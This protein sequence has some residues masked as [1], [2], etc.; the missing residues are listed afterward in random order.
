M[1]IIKKYWGYA[2]VAL[3][4]LILL[5]G[6][7][8][9]NYQNEISSK[10][11]RF[12]VLANSNRQ[13]DQDLKLEVRDAVIEYLETILET[14]E[15]AEQSEIQ[16]RTHLKDIEAAAQ[17]AVAEQGYSYEVSARLGQNYFPEKS[18]GDMVFPSGMYEA[19]IVDIGNAVGRN[20][21]CVLFPQL[22]FTDA[23]TAYV[24]EE[25]KDTLRDLLS[26]EAYQ[27]L[28]EGEDVEYRFKIAEV[29]TR[30]FS[31]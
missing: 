8:S 17:A 30:L 6:F 20:W 28:Y 3:T 13:E 9:N 21:W 15:T 25:S 31:E 4:A 19:L 10:I 11:L 26:N 23:V 22:C 16:I 18:Y 1:N 7:S 12:H 14:C 5:T 2:G 29:I 27:T 24:P